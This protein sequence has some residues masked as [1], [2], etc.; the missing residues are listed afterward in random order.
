MHR[1]TK[2]NLPLSS[3]ISVEASHSNSEHSWVRAAQSALLANAAIASHIIVRE[4][5][6]MPV[7]IGCVHQ[8]RV[9]L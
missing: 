3:H 1:K 8:S 6:P 5:I 9:V 2:V 4:S 7:D